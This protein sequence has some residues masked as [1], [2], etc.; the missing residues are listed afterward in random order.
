MFSGFLHVLYIPVYVFLLTL[1]HKHIR[2]YELLLQ[3]T[4]ECHG[5]EVHGSTYMQAFFNKCTGIFFE[6]F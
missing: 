2:F 4:L 5:F 3:L 6:I 1:C